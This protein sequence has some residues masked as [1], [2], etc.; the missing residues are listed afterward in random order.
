MAQTASSNSGVNGDVARGVVAAVAGAAA[1][2]LAAREAVRRSRGPR[3]FGYRLPRELRPG[4]LDLKRLAKQ[5]E[6]LA[7]RVEHTSEDVRVASA[8]ARRVTSRLS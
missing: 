3:V 1:V 5:I 2:A 6:R 8:Q 7:E 4:S